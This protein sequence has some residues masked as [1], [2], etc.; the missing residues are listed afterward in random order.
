MGKPEQLSDPGLKRQKR[1]LLWAVLI[2]ALIWGMVIGVGAF[3]QDPLRGAIVFC[4]VLVVIGLWTLALLRYQ[5]RGN[6]PN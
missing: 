6:A 2:G 1:R 4:V 3:L 5:R